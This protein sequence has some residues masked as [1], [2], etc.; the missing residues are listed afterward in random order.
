MRPSRSSFR[1]LPDTVDAET[2]S[3]AAMSRVASPGPPRSLA[4][5]T[6]LT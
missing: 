4:F 5:Q 1:R 3:V 6:S 2:L